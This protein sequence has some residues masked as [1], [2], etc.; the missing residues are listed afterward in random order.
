MLHSVAHIHKPQE[1]RHSE[2]LKNSFEFLTYPH[3]E[4]GRKR[5]GVLMLNQSEKWLKWRRREEKSIEDSHS[6]MLY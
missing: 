5:E 3:I 6:V 2:I 4:A 1:R